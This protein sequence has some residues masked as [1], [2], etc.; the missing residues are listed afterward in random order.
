MSRYTCLAVVRLPLWGQTEGLRA[1]YTILPLK[2]SASIALLLVH[3]PAQTP[4][5]YTASFLISTTETTAKQ[6]LPIALQMQATIPIM[7]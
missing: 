2:E 5:P 1:T 3:A 7:T 6:S 4:E